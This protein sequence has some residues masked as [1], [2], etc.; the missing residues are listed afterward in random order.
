MAATLASQERHSMGDLTLHV[1]KF[2]A[3]AVSDTYALTNSPGIIG[4]WGCI[5]AGSGSGGLAL[6]FTNSASGGT[7]EFVVTAASSANVYVLAQG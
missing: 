4:A 2:S 5:W 7:L 1:L 3:I 6:N